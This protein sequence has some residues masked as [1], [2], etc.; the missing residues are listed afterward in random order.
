MPPCSNKLLQ[1]GRSIAPAFVLLGTMLLSGSPEAI[2]ALPSAKQ[3]ALYEQADEAS[4]VKL[5]IHLSKTGAH[6]Q[7]DWLLRQYPLQGAHA[8]NRTLFIEGLILKSGGDYT[9]ATGK[10]RSALAADPKLTLVRAELAQTLVVLEQDDSALYHLKQLSAEAPN[11]KAAD[12]LRTFM[13]KVDERSPFRKSFWIAA[14]PSSNVNGGSTQI[15][16]TKPNLKPPKPEKAIGVS[17][18]ANVGYSKRLGNDFSLAVGAGA[19]GTIYADHAYSSFS[20]NQ[21]LEIRRLLKTGYIGLGLVTN[22]SM[23]VEVRDLNSLSYG[24]RLSLVHAFNNKNS[25]SANATYEWRNANENYIS[26]SDGNALMLNGNFTHAFSQGFS[27][28][29]TLGYV[30]VDV[31]LDTKSFEMVSGEMSVHKEMPFGLTADVSARLAHTQFNGALIVRPDPTL[32]TIVALPEREDW[33]AT[34]SIELTKRDLNILGFAP[35]LS[36]TYSNTSSSVFLYNTDNHSVDLR[37]TKDF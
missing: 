23:N 31:E 7:A 36:Y 15:D 3:R 22:Q 24:P 37:F 20:L 18:G 30:D 21:S 25:I 32:P 27:V 17:G 1:W 35:A 9:G 14:A 34:A 5:L 12:D 33:T 6:E 10:F 2:A 29:A 26:G 8:A 28:T 4:R 11:E 19:S 13:E 16:P